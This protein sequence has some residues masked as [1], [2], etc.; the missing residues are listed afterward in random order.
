MDGTLAVE[1]ARVRA[2]PVVLAFGKSHCFMDIAWPPVA[3]FAVWF[4]NTP[5]AH[6]DPYFA[7]LWRQMLG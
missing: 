3:V 1:L 2:D 5:T 4:G 7:T 6:C